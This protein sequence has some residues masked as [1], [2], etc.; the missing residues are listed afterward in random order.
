MLQFRE[1]DASELSCANYFV[2]CSRGDRRFVAMPVFPSRSFRHSCI[3]VNTQAGVREPADLKGKRLGCAEYSMTA[4][5]WVRAF[6]QHDYRVMP[7]DLRWVLGGLEQPGRRERIAFTPPEGVQV[8]AAPA[9]RALVPM[10]EAGE[11]DAL[12][13]PNL[14]SAFKAGSPLVK[15]LF[16]DF[17]RVEAEYYQRTGVFPIMHTI[18]LRREVYER[19]P[20][21][22]LSLYKAFCAAKE[23]AVARLFESDAL[24]ISLAWS[25]AYAEQERV[26][27]GP[28]LWSYG[29]EANSTTLEALK[30]HLAEQ[31]LLERDFAIE[32]AFAPSTLE[33]TRL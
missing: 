33:T 22:A 14:P 2:L 16:P 15:R 9:D 11:I 19:H 27:R 21:A 31:G 8:E 24:A 26:V 20:W 4:A 32:D 1:F 18:V 6:L 13:A 12:I 30:A 25:V 28:D 7:G 23:L 5:V 10:L 3:Y 29:L 17:P